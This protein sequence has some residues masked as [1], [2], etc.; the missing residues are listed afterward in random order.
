MQTYKIIKDFFD[1]FTTNVKNETDEA[2]VF[3]YE[4]HLNFY[5]EI[6]DDYIDNFSDNI[7]EIIMLKDELIKFKKRYVQYADIMNIRINKLFK[8]V[9]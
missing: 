5:L 2:L 1:E 4:N 8:Q 9:V 3:M 6:L 7:E